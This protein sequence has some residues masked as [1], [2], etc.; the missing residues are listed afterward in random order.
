MPADGRDA[1]AAATGIVWLASY[2][3]SGNTWFRIFVANLLRQGPDPANIAELGTGPIASS[4][5]LFDEAVGYSSA[6]LGSEAVGRLRPLVY[7]EMAAASD[8]TLL[9]KIHDAYAPNAD[10]RPLVSTK[11]TRGCIYFIRD[12]LDVCVSFAHH[13]GISMEDALEAMCDES[14]T[15]ADPPDRLERQLPQ[16]LLSWRRHVLSWVDEAPFPV[17]VVRYEDMHASPLATFAE[18]TEFAGLRYPENL[19]EEAIRK[20]EFSGLQRQEA[21]HGFAERFPKG[22]SFFRKGVVGS[23]RDE[24]TP[25]QATRLARSQRDVMRRFGY[26]SI[27]DVSIH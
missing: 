6:D 18:A 15:L 10:G 16:Q 24:L 11:A 23:W 17:L 9:V 21:L 27:D 3:K 20:S 8:T 5:R 13:L 25:D 22:N 14:L 19:V 4:R 1:V 7:D 2:P 26:V 12:P